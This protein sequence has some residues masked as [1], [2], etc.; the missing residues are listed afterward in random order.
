MIPDTYSGWSTTD[1]SLIFDHLKSRKFEPVKV[2][3]KVAL[4]P[5]LTRG[6][7]EALTSF[8]TETKL[9]CKIR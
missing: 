1:V 9:N 3:D 5:A 2:Q 6:P 4:S 7:L 8:F